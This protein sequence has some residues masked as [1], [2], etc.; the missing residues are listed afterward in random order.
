MF[1][2]ASLDYKKYDQN[3]YNLIPLGFSDP[4]EIKR[5]KVLITKESSG[6][7]QLYEAIVPMV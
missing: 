3:S 6:R 2:M 4:K 5:I 7:L 1:T